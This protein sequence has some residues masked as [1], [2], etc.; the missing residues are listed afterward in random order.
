MNTT[1]TD[2]QKRRI[3][4]RKQGSRTGFFSYLAVFLAVLTLI[5]FLTDLAPQNRLRRAWDR[6]VREIE[7]DEAVFALIGTALSEGSIRL[8]SKDTQILYAAA[9]P[10]RA[11]VS[12]S[13]NGE[14]LVAV[15]E[16]D[17]FSLSVDGEVAT[18]ERAAMAEELFA[19]PYDALSE[20][21]K[22][23]LRAFLLVT[24]TSFS[25]GT[26]ASVAE[27][28]LKGAKPSLTRRGVS[29][30]VGEKTRS[31]TE[32]RFDFDSRAMTRALKTLVEE[33]QHNKSRQALTQMGEAL[34]LFGGGGGEKFGVI[35]DFLDGKGELYDSVAARLEEKSWASLSFT[36]Q[37]D[38][39]VSV[40]FAFRIGEEEANF[41]LDLSEG[42]AESGVRL[43]LSMNG[44]AL[45]V[46][47]T[48][49]ES[50]ESYLRTWQWTLQNGEKKEEG[51]IRFSRGKEKGDVGLR[52]KFGEREWYWRATL[53]KYRAGKEISLKISRIERDRENLL[54]EPV[55]VMISAKRGDMA[56]LEKGKSLPFSDADSDALHR[57][58]ENRHGSI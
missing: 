18:G 22:G 5:G 28:I 21:E 35:E 15:C 47:Q 39:V 40:S 26:A 54:A 58:F 33:A 29:R 42:S 24:R 56:S 55:T 11:S 48:V 32:Y 43:M 10:K 50:R 17:L 3:P 1:T 20:N 53:E 4:R 37:S 31:A 25:D 6:T 2:S 19:E 14:S 52:M 34:V 9:L 49:E 12:V 36:V 44:Q 27:R 7:S 23:L 13:G 57:T 41:S 46:S 38:K 51:S 30:T 16:K 8:E 45:T